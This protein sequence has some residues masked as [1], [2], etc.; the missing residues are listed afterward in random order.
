MK[1]NILLLFLQERQKRLQNNKLFF[2]LKKAINV[3]AAGLVKM[4]E[5]VSSKT[6]EQGKPHALFVQENAGL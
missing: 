1:K 4:L 3:L 2:F 6:R 5:F